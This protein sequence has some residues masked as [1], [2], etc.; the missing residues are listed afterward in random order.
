[1]VVGAVVFIAATAGWRAAT[2]GYDGS[3]APASRAQY[4]YPGMLSRTLYSPE[5]P[6]GPD[7][8]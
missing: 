3:G 5:S 8:M 1:M 6:H 7:V 2:S 4:G